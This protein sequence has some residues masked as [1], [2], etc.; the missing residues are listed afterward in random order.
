[1]HERLEAKRYILQQVSEG[2][3]RNLPGTR[4]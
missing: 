4:F 3:N 2:T 1:M